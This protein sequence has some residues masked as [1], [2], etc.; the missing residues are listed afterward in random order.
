M[1]ILNP[2]GFLY[3]NTHITVQQGHLRIEGSPYGDTSLAP[4]SKHS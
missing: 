2:T 1:F 3:F 4:E